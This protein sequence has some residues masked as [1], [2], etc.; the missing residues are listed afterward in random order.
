MVGKLLGSVGNSK[1]KHLEKINKKLPDVIMLSST[2]FI[3]INGKRNN[4]V[5]GQKDKGR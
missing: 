3:K 2:H 4:S 5:L 1:T